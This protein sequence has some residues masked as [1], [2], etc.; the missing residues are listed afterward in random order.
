M[1][2]RPLENGLASG[3]A[4][5]G[6]IGGSEASAGTVAAASGFW[7]FECVLLAP[8]G[9]ILLRA[10][11][12]GIP[13]DVRLPS[14]R[15]GTDAANCSA[16]LQ[17]WGVGAVVWGG[18]SCGLLSWRAGAAVCSLLGREAQT[19]VLGARRGRLR[20]TQLVCGLL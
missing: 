9:R 13:Q 1:K 19:A 14:H 15:L 3:G 16:V 2:Q 8:F 18:C 17:C 4:Q 5:R 12:F 6:R 20:Y 10:W 11:G 7:G